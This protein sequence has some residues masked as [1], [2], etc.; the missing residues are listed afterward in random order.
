MRRRLQR[1]APRGRDLKRYGELRYRTAHRSPYSALEHAD[2]DCGE[3]GP[4]GQLGLCDA[5]C[6]AILLE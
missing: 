2:K 5:S 6:T 1:G 4:L 3:A